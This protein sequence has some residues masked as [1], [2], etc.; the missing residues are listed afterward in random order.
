MGAAAVARR[1][2]ECST[3]CRVERWRTRQQAQV[4]EG[5]GTG[6]Q[7]GAG[8]GTC[9]HKGGH[10][11]EARES[12]PGCALESRLLPHRPPLG[13]RSR[14]REASPR[15]DELVLGVSLRDTQPI[16][17]VMPTLPA[18]MSMKRKLHAIQ[19]YISSFEYVCWLCCGRGDAPA[20]L[21]VVAMAALLAC[22]TPCTRV[23]GRDD[24]SRRARRCVVAAG[25]TTR[26]NCTSTCDAT[27]GCKS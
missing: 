26:A 14:E 21:S 15:G 2:H 22:H 18:T 10:N 3:G 6:D 7:A 9:R 12:H 1:C 17:P 24:T 4:F 11:L 19:R 8:S 16:M 13:Y 5:E 20:V 27:R 23:A 25:T